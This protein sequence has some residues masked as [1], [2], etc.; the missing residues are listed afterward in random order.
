ML[1]ILNMITYRQMKKLS[2]NLV[3]LGNEAYISWKVM[4]LNLV[5]ILH[6]TFLFSTFSV[7][8]KIGK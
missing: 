2:S 5:P 4:I 3:H 7:N 6:T 1:Y 8:C